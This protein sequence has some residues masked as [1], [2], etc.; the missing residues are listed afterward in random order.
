MYDGQ[1]TTDGN[2]LYPEY[3]D[4]CVA[5]YAPCIGGQGTKLFNFAGDNNPATLTNFTLSAAWGLSQGVQSLTFNATNSYGAASQPGNLAGMGQISIS[6]WVLGGTGSNH[7][8]ILVLP[9]NVAW[10]GGAAH[11]AVY[12]IRAESTG[13]GVINCW[14][15]DFV[16]N[17]FSGATSIGSTS[18]RHVVLT[19]DGITQRLY[20]DGA[21]DATKALSGTSITATTQPL[22]F[23]TRNST[24]LGE[25]FGGSLDDV[26]I[27][28]RCLTPGEIRVLSKLGR[29]G[30][31]T[32]VV[33][34]GFV[35]AAAIGNRRR[36]LLATGA[37]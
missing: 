1:F 5:A 27:L 33:T 11:Y 8:H 36:R 17:N 28:N 20:I 16:A 37:I 19:W 21:Q 31:Y 7:S 29:G 15:N 12:G 3:W 14:V 23:G 10:G 35:A 6:L 34:G 30:A 9:D 2:W 32:P 24:D 18:W 22:A 25:Y 26:R 4:G 13:T